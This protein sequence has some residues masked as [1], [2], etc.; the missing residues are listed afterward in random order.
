MTQEANQTVKRAWTLLDEMQDVRTLKGMK[1]YIPK[2]K[3]A[4][5]GIALFINN[6][7]KENA[8]LTMQYDSVCV[9]L[10][11]ERKVTKVLT[12]LIRDLVTPN[13]Q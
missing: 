13:A 10:Q 5:D 1:D 3:Q 7:E 11:V 8:S 6:V 2:V 9:S 4:L 12:D